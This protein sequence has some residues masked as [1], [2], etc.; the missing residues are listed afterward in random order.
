MSLRSDTAASPN[1]TESWPWRGLDDVSGT[2]PVPPLSLEDSEQFSRSLGYSFERPVQEQGPT[3]RS[4]ISYSTAHRSNDDRLHPFDGRRP[5]SQM[6]TSRPVPTRQPSGTFARFGNSLFH[7]HRNEADPDAPIS[8]RRRGSL[9]GLSR[10]LTM[11]AAFRREGSF[12]RKGA[13]THNK[14]AP[15]S[16]NS[17]QTV[18]SSSDGASSEPVVDDA[19][20]APVFGP[21]PSFLG[22]EQTR[23]SPTE[24][25]PISRTGESAHPS[26][27]VSPLAHPASP[28]DS[29][30]VPTSAIPIPQP[31]ALSTTPLSFSSVP[32]SSSGPSTVSENHIIAAYEDTHDSAP[33]S[34]EDL[35]LTVSPTCDRINM[36]GSLQVTTNYSLSG[37]VRLNVVGHAF[38]RY[39][40]KHFAVI[41]TGYS[42]YSDSSG[43][44]ASTK[45]C[46]IREP[47]QQQPMHVTFGDVGACECEFDLFM[48]GWLPASFNSRNSS[49][50]YSV[51][52]VATV[53][54]IR[55][56]SA[57]RLIVIQRSR[58]LVPIP[59]AQMA[60]FNGAPVP[61]VTELPS[62]NPFRASSNPFRA[63][64]NPF[65][66]EPESVAADETVTTQAAAPRR[67]SEDRH[68]ADRER[69]ARRVLLR[70]FAHA[71]HLL[72]PE[73]LGGGKLPIKITLSVPSH[74]HTTIHLDEDQPPLL[75]G[76][77]IELDDSWTQAR[78]VGGLRL[79][80]L[81]AMCV[82]MEKYVT[83]PS[84]SYC[85]AF[86]LQSEGKDI[87]AADLPRFDRALLRDFPGYMEDKG[88]ALYP[89]NM[90]YIKNR[91]RL[92]MSGIE[93][94]E[95]DNVAE[96]FHSHTVGPLPQD[97]PEKRRSSVHQEDV[98]EARQNADASAAPAPQ[99]PRSNSLPPLRK[100]VYSGALSR[101]SSFAA[102]IRDTGDQPREPG[103]HRNSISS[104]S[105]RESHDR[106]R[107]FIK[108]SYEFEG[109][110]GQ[111]LEL[112]KRRERLS[113]SLP[114]TPSSSQRSRSLGTVQLLPDYESPHVRIRHKLKVKLTFGFGAAGSPSQSLVLC[115]PARFT[116]AP[117]N[118]ALAQASPIVFPPAAR[119][120]IPA[121]G[122]PATAVPAAYTHATR[123]PEAGPNLEGVPYL[124]AYTQ[125]FR[126]DGS[127]LGDSLEELPQYP[128]ANAR[129]PR[130]PDE[131][132]LSARL[133]R[134]FPLVNDR[135]RDEKT[136]ASTSYL[137]AA[138]GDMMPDADD[139][140]E[141]HAQDDDMMLM[142]DSAGG[143]VDVGDSTEIVTVGER[144]LSH[145][146]APAPP[147]SAATLMPQ[148]SFVP[149]SMRTATS[150]PETTAGAAAAAAAPAPA[151]PPAAAPAAAAPLS[152]AAAP[153]SP[154]SPQPPLTAGAYGT[155]A[156]PVHSSLFLRSG[157]TATMRMG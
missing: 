118:E 69:L 5:S 125:L 14:P 1:I 13:Q 43:R 75:F 29:S 148:M 57:P 83:T 146:T 33:P 21:G 37:T 72:L 12:R 28:T 138:G 128:D 96:R 85:T 109:R 154:T 98:A 3:R 132:E 67:T 122:A 66:S 106:S 92:E 142:E 87:R 45:V 124:P 104:Q 101:L 70:H 16:A 105:R 157:F 97:I 76:V 64:P 10:R 35:Q 41:L 152:Y 108:A 134:I 137:E 107:D 99:T 78:N 74:T 112:T 120:C 51:H 93:P 139:L 102:A 25:N 155:P 54:G 2:S 86:A 95:W 31:P 36:F 39:E 52:A 119:S 48:P 71:Q 111:G 123:A 94:A 141:I 73:S 117:A 149:S 153:V 136:P 147:I 100:R 68:Q 4:S 15:N 121:E 46:E 110:D 116:E 77:Q 9:H 88:S 60:I 56:D 58:E 156:P 50:F 65:V 143:L 23:S 6:E 81:E 49:T 32:V 22:S 82:Q 27:V 19:V 17:W 24:M 59:V 150:A 30:S 144:A 84:R 91:M 126:E 90:F 115:V 44:Y 7:G 135:V 103:T 55:V 53:A 61:E 47:L 114:L 63:S 131:V 11:P 18:Q 151:P 8:P 34:A 89:Y 113:F 133:A 40:V 38:G 130:G 145:A 80:E 79:R 20:P 129:P 62:R 140:V 127:R 26:H 42:I